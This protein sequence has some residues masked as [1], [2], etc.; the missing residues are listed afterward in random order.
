[1]SS[2]PFHSENFRKITEFDVQVRQC[3][4]GIERIER[5]ACCAV[6]INLR[7]RGIDNSVRQVHRITRTVQL[8]L[9]PRNPGTEGS[10]H[11]GRKVPAVYM[12]MTVTKDGRG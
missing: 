7:L 2:F 8:W 10:H 5:R 4:M 1:M 6:D 11:G 9:A 3:D 12:V